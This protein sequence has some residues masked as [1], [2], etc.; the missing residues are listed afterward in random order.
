MLAIQALRFASSETRS[1]VVFGVDEVVEL[2]D[3][4]LFLA[5]V[6]RSFIFENELGLELDELLL[7][8]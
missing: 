7:A 3:T 2:W 8:W 6:V 5:S 1:L 4:Q